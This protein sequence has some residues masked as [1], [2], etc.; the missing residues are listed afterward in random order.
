MKTW[1]KFLSEQSGNLHADLFDLI[2]QASDL[3][4]KLDLIQSKHPEVEEFKNLEVSIL[5]IIRE[6]E[7]MRRAS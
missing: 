7:S 5:K 1:N 3:R 2:Q 6:L 4:Y